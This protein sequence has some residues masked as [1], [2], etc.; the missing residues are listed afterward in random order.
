MEA[1]LNDGYALLMELQK[2]M[3]SNRTTTSLTKQ[4]CTSQST[5]T[6]ATI[7]GYNLET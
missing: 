4:V 6:V 3:Y 1:H 2:S 7:A 5:L